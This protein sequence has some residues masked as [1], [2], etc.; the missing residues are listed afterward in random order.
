MSAAVSNMARMFTP[1][2]LWTRKKRGK[3]NVRSAGINFDE[4][5]DMDPDV[6]H[7]GLLDVEAPQ[8]M[9]RKRLTVGVHRMDYNGDGDEEDDEDT[10]DDGGAD[11]ENVE[12]QR[13]KSYLDES[14]Q[15]EYEAQ[16]QE[17]YAAKEKLRSYTSSGRKTGKMV[18]NL[19]DFVIK[20]D[21]VTADPLSGNLYRVWAFN[22]FKKPTCALWNG[23]V[24]F[25][26]NAQF[27]GTLFIL[28]IQ[29]LGP[30]MIIL[31]ILYGW[32]SDDEYDFWKWKNFT[33]SKEWVG[34]DN[35]RS[36]RILGLMF[37]F[38]FIANCMKVVL[39]EAESFEKVWSVF[40]VLQCE[41]AKGMCSLPLIIGP[42]VNCLITV[43][44]SIA[45]FLIMGTAENPKDIVFDALGITFLFNLDDIGGDMAFVSEEDWPG[46]RLRWIYD[47][48]VKG[49]NEDE[50]EDPPPLWVKCLYNGT[51]AVLLLMS[52][53][54][55]VLYCLIPW[56]N[57]KVE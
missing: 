8:A 22:G 10:Y 13:L 52:I 6:A 49:D 14:Q 30:P 29:V 4:L 55:P 38:C 2:G 27:V 23:R 15:A 25:D 40:N 45:V 44:C 46:D 36:T 53:V 56:S 48:M 21:W 35:K 7:G 37:L 31:G 54:L 26:R 57:L 24:A 17:E 18:M 39:S 9:Q 3:R 20:E 16:M 19:I 41:K 32:G 28:L 12:M 47:N 50:Q 5:V 51:Y 11:A 1:K 42:L 33:E 34:E 43:S